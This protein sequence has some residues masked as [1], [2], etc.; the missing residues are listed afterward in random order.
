MSIKVV[1]II[2]DLV[3]VLGFKF[4]KTWCTCGEPL[5][6]EHHY[7][8]PKCGSKILWKDLIINE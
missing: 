3:N 2:T 7:Y 1:P 8:C 5:S 6:R 4:F